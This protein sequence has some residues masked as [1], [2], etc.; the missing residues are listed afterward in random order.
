M[1][2]AMGQNNNRQGSCHTRHNVCWHWMIFPL[3]LNGG[4]HNSADLH[5]SILPPLHAVAST[6]ANSFNCIVNEPIGSELISAQV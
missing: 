3:T 6:Q 4:L 2:Q 1:K 5:E